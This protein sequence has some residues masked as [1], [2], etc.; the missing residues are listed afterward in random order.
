MSV[1]PVEITDFISD[2]VNG[3]GSESVD[4]Q[5]AVKSIIATGVSQA[6]S[7]RS[8]MLKQ[9]RYTAANKGFTR[10]SPIL[11]TGILTVSN[12][13]LDAISKVADSAL[14][15]AE[16]AQTQQAQAVGALIPKQLQSTVEIAVNQI[17]LDGR[18]AVNAIEIATQKGL[19]RIEIQNAKDVSVEVKKYKSLVA[20]ANADGD[21]AAKKI[22]V[23]KS[24]TTMQDV[25]KITVKNRLDVGVIKY[26][27][28]FTVQDNLLA[29]EVEGKTKTTAS[30]ITAATNMSTAKNTAATNEATARYDGAVMVGDARIYA[31]DTT[32][33]AE[34]D[35]SKQISSARIT[36]QDK[37]HTAKTD[38]FK[39]TSTAK[40]T[41]LTSTSGA[42]LSAQSLTS[43]ER[44][45]AFNM[46]AGARLTETGKQITERGFATGKT[47]AA[48]LTATSTLRTA[49]T[50]A[51]TTEFSGI[52][53]ARALTNAEELRNDGLEKGIRKTLREVSNGKMV[54]Q[55]GAEF[56][57]RMSAI[58]TKYSASSTATNN[59]SLEVIRLKGLE[60]TEHGVQAGNKVIAQKYATGQENLANLYRINKEVT[61]RSSIETMRNAL[62]E[63]IANAQVAS[64]KLLM[65]ND[66]DARKSS[67]NLRSAARLTANDVKNSSAESRASSNAKALK[68]A[69]KGKSTARD[70]ANKKENQAYLDT[71]PLELS[72]KTV[73]DGKESQERTNAAGREETAYIQYLKD[74]IGLE[75]GKT[76]DLD[77]ARIKSLSAILDAQGKALDKHNEGV[78]YVQRLTDKTRNAIVKSQLAMDLNSK[79]QAAYTSTFLEVQNTN[80]QK[81]I[82]KDARIQKHHYFNNK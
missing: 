53:G 16:S 59:E 70:L 29:K 12:T 13:Y 20:H 14:Q 67:A 61:S 71:L 23:S 1:I 79:M 2:V 78:D 6:R 68:D 81:L 31:A 7:A 75:L 82:A 5:K 60:N 50:T 74:S 56:T 17:E 47:N 63:R 36:A 80:T 40:N 26:D 41:A 28:E 25:N 22:E 33:N 24:I 35:K 77:E 9:A 54:T 8:E 76:K 37:E 34:I 11:N 72:N 43:A 45:S 44:L 4:L 73:I 51:V 62:E 32:G 55:R 30:R 57:E 10:L 42:R 58:T 39:L 3:T 46:T 49:H 21:I 48:N 64:K 66:L 65:E 19:A 38:A 27:A 69:D 18:K 52:T 15:F